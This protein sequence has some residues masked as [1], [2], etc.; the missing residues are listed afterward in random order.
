MMWL[1][2]AQVRGGGAW[3]GSAPQAGGGAPCRAPGKFKKEANNGTPKPKRWN[4]NPSESISH[5]IQAQLAHAT[6]LHHA[7]T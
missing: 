7:V 4:K 5:V 3:T 6:Q 2:R 1:G